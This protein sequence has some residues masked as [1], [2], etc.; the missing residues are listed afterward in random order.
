MM[1]KTEVLDMS[2]LLAKYA[3]KTMWEMLKDKANNPKNK[4]K[5]FIVMWRLVCEKRPAGTLLQNLK[6]LKY[7]A[8]LLVDCNSIQNSHGVLCPGSTQLK[9]FIVS[10]FAER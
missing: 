1:R 4:A 5:F 7:F 3:S 6:W 9:H 8:Y 10:Y 2:P